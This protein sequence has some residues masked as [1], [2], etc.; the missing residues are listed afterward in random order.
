MLEG[1]TLTGV[2][3]RGKH[4]LLQLSSGATLHVHFKMGGDWEFTRST[5]ALP[6]HA[7]F[8]LEFVNG[9]RASLT[10]PRALCTVRYHAPNAPP[11]LE[12]G[13]EAD[14][15][16]LTATLLRTAFSA[17]RGAIKAVL[18]DQR[19][20]AGVGNIYASE[21]LWRAKLHPAII[22]STLGVARVERLLAGIRAAFAD[23]VLNAGTYRTGVRVVPFD[24]YDREGEPCVRCGAVIKRLVQNARSTYFCAGCQR[25]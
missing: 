6:R 14:D 9:V 16:T 8:S 15:P 2:Q 10:D 21:A 3:R 12:L 1:L 13:P 5:A 24:V 17:K 18:L 23:G 7:R 25:R 11:A 4:Q 22:A 20:L 19:V